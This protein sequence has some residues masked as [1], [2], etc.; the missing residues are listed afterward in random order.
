MKK[1]KNSM[2]KYF[3]LNLNEF[4]FDVINHLIQLIVVF[5]N[6]FSLKYFHLFHDSKIF[7]DLNIHYQDVSLKIYYLELISMIIFK[8]LMM[9]IIRFDYL[10][11]K[12][13]RSIEH[14]SIFYL[15]KSVNES[16][17]AAIAF[18]SINAE[19]IKWKKIK[20]KKS[21]TFNNHHHTFNISH[22]T[23]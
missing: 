15:L 8:N 19:I 21:L 4:V 10:L 23:S 3:D 11:K 12:Q 20:D 6:V 5:L 2:M 13:N 1:K 16:W 22:F 18:F 17:S 14:K 7:V 9:L